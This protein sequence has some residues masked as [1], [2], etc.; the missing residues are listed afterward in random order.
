MSQPVETTAP[1][2][3]AEGVTTEG[4]ES[5]T[6]SAESQETKLS[7]EELQAEVKRVRQE[8]AARRVAN[9]EL[10]EKAKKWSEYE[11][12][13]KSELQKLQ[14]QLAERDKAINDAKLE[15][16]RALIAKE[17]NVADED[18][19]LL[20]GD[21]DNMKR[22]AAR[23][24]KKEEGTGTGTPPSNLLAGNRGKPVGA[25]SNFSVDDW[26]RGRRSN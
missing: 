9:R 14:D 25:G 23:L 1:E 4:T 20:V 8:A 6:G 16:K 21:E 11:E 2:T 18:L 17:F 26:M 7:Y 5:Q 12:S 13:Q 24:G 15:A 3:K 22:L 19:D 10:E